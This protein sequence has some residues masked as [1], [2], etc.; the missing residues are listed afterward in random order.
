MRT[1][2][3]ALHQKRA[4]Y[5]AETRKRSSPGEAGTHGSTLLRT[6][7]GHEKHL[8]QVTVGHKELGDE[9]HVVVARGVAKL[10]RRGLTGPELV[11]QV[12]QV[13]R[14]ALPAV[15]V[16]AVHVQ[17]LCFCRERNTQKT[18]RQREG[19]AGRGGDCVWG[20]VWERQHHALLIALRRRRLNTIITLSVPYQNNASSP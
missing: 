4:R 15:V 5:C 9:V 7:L 11:V 8:D 6:C 3:A 12:R 1:A 13:K 17:D 18:G 16:V 19:K 10:G 20:Y 2:V 14:R